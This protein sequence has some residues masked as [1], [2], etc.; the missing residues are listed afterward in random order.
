MAGQR[1]LATDRM[2]VTRGAGRSSAGSNI[3]M[4]RTGKS[5]T[6]RRPVVP[7]RC[8]PAPPHS[9]R[10]RPAANVDPYIVVRLLIKNTLL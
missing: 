1:L 6:G 5:D 7:P 2:G 4:P 8:A 3:G 10:S 9:P